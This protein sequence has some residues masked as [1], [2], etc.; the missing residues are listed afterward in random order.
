[1]TK[2]LSRVE[3]RCQYRRRNRFCG[4]W[5]RYQ[6]RVKFTSTNFIRS[7]VY[8]FE[9]LLRY[10]NMVFLRSTLHENGNV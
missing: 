7:L 10:F 6:G 2:K 8:T 5:W 3:S 1:M 4:S 9:K